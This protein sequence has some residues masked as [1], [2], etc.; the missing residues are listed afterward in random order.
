MKFK[1][2][3]IV[4]SI[5]LFALT[6][7]AKTI[8]ADD[9]ASVGGD[10]DELMPTAPQYNISAIAVTGGTVSGSGTFDEGASVTLTATP[11]NSGY[12]FSGWS[13]DASGTTNPLTITADSDKTI[14]ANFVIPNISG[15]PKTPVNQTFIDLLGDVESSGDSNPTVTLISNGGIIGWYD[16]DSLSAAVDPT[17][18]MPMLDARGRPEVIYYTLA[19]FTGSTTFTFPENQKIGIYAESDQNATLAYWIVDDEVKLSNNPDNITGGQQ[20]LSMQHPHIIIDSNVSTLEAVFV[21]IPNEASPYIPPLNGNSK[22]IS[23]GGVIQWISPTPNPVV[24]RDPTTGMPLLDESG[25]PTVIRTILGYFSGTQEYSFPS[26]S[27]LTFY[28][29]PKLNHTFSYWLVDGIANLGV[30]ND[31]DQYIIPSFPDKSITVQSSFSTLEAVYSPIPEGSADYIG[32]TDSNATHYTE[33]WFYHPSRGWMWTDRSAYPYFY[34]ATDKDW[35]YF[36]SGNDKP[37]FYR[38]KTKT[39]LTVE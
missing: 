35:M 22:I 16:Q 34:D 7:K 1:Y 37:K 39:W 33:G 15:D 24:E 23:N 20:I 18:G 21:P 36:Q 13:G 9:N 3:S 32:A 4:T 5:C 25:K 14:T 27:D 17:T 30:V 2:F 6:S 12:I 8:Y 28:A 26:T 10:G 38:Y 11:S 31:S 19:L 29:E